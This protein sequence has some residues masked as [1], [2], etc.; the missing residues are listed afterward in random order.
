MKNPLRSQ[1]SIN[2]GLLLA[3][4]PVGALF[5]TA[6]YKKIFSMGV[7]KFVAMASQTGRVPS[8]V[9]HQWVDMYLHAV[10]YLEIT[11]G[12]LVVLGLFGRVGGLI[13]SLMIVTFIIGATGL[14]DANLPFTPN[15]IYLAAM[16]LVLL[17]G[18]GGFSLDGLMFGRRKA[19]AA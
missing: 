1:S 11:V 5:L 10:P 14:S 8:G 18:P 15:L 17:V 12:L 3:R 6:G 9:P 4:L 7:D 13:G 16:L 2:L 19:T